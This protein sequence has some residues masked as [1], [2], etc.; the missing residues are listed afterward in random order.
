MREYE[1]RPGDAF[2]VM[3]PGRLPRLIAWFMDSKF[4]HCGMV[5][6]QTGQRV[7]TCETSDFEVAYF[8]LAHYLG[9][10]KVRMVILR[11]P[12]VDYR[13]VEMA[14]EAASHQRTIY[15]FAQLIFSLS[16]RELIRKLT[17]RVIPN[18]LRQG[19][20]CC[21][22]VLYGCRK[23]GIPRLEMQDPEGL[24]TQ[25]THDLLLQCGAEVV[26]QK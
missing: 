1:P 14:C 8:D 9:D 21:H 22:V 19:M 3:N 16:V 10:P 13:A 4:S 17:R 15:G 7:Y 23:S 6:E 11:L 2:F 5:L 12:V 24:Q 25:E 26:F 18:F 20:V